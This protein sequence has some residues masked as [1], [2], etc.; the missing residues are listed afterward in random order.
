MIGFYY[1]QR[2]IL[3][4]GIKSRMKNGSETEPKIYF[5]QDFM[6]TTQS[7]Q[8][9]YS[10]SLLTEEDEISTCS[11]VIWVFKKDFFRTKFESK[12]IFVIIFKYQ[13]K[14]T[15]FNSKLHQRDYVIFY[16]SFV[17]KCSYTRNFTKSKD[18]F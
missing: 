9:K 7:M 14:Y 2:I 12:R 4:E 11:Y 1:A 3:G 17:L 15:T 6:F 10:Q 5:K 16:S 13:S 8:T 18:D